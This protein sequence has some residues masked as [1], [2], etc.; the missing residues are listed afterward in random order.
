MKCK[1]CN[2][3]IPLGG[4]F[5]PKCGNKASTNTICKKDLR[6]EILQLKEGSDDY[7]LN[8]YYDRVLEMLDTEKFEKVKY[9][10]EMFDWD[11]QADL[12]KMIKEDGSIKLP[13][14]QKEKIKSIVI[15]STA[16]MVNYFESIYSGQNEI[17]TGL[18]NDRV[19]YIDAAYTQYQRDEIP[20]A[21][22]NMILGMNMIKKEL[23]EGLEYFS[24]LP[25]STWKKIIS[26]KSIRHTDAMLNNLKES[27]DRYIVA[28][29]L[30][31]GIDAA[32]GDTKKVLNTI[33]REIEYLND[34]TKK[35]G[36]IRLLEYDDD[37]AQQWKKKI[38]NINEK[39][40][41]VSERLETNSLI[42]K[43]EDN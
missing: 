39:L 17:L 41:I 21:S 6:E 3:E 15:L 23:N 35:Y 19:A 32:E 43:L 2:T 24:D 37:H 38:N 27:M 11:M 22:N 7:Q 30:L 42:L 26:F 10:Y 9:T 14:I 16:I 8:E 13:I 12:K 29:C 5:C 18:H 28:T 33:D 34:L 31:V 4:C 25:K 40:H 1:I 20:Q 36:Y